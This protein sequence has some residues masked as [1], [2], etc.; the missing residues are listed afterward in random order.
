[1]KIYHVFYDK[2]YY[3]FH[4]CRMHSVCW[5]IQ[6]HGTAPWAIS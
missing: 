4:S 5:H 6:I 1:M 2:A 3:C